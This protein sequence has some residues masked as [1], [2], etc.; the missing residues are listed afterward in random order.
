[1]AKV[2]QQNGKMLSSYFHGNINWEG[3][4]G[5]LTVAAFLMLGQM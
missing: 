3:C 5:V 4:L 1:M 2:L